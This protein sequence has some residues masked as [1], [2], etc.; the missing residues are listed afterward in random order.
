MGM[1]GCFRRVSATDLQRLKAN[2]GEIDTFLRDNGESGRY[3]PFADFDVDKSWHGIHFLLTGSAWGDESLLSFIC[4][5]GKEIGEE[6]GYDPPRA[7][8]PAEVQ[9]LAAALESLPAEVLA[10]RY[11]PERM[12]RLKIYPEIWGRDGDDGKSYI[13]EYYEG[14]RDFILG[15]AR[16]GE[17][18]L[19]YLS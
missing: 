5:G 4:F 16:E 14:L 17:G 7:F 10:D 9:Q 13:L 6:Y 12:D 3:E 11:D 1:V 2:P 15:G 19:V 18:L 8:D